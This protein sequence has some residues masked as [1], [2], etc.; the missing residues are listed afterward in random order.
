[1]ALLFPLCL[2]LGRERQGAVAVTQGHAGTIA[3]GTWGRVTVQ[4]GGECPISS[5]RC[6]C[7]G[8]SLAL[9]FISMF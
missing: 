6:S 4:G 5:L 8:S 3:E 2:A 1:M 9:T 7:G